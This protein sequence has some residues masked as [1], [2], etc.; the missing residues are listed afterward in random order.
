MELSDFGNVPQGLDGKDF[1]LFVQEIAQH[2]P[3]SVGL[4]LPLGNVLSA[5][6]NEMGA[7]RMIE[8]W[9]VCYHNT[10][11]W[12]KSAFVSKSGTAQQPSPGKR[13][14]DPAAS[15]FQEPAACLRTLTGYLLWAAGIPVL[16]YGSQKL[17]ILNILFVIK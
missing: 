16:R 3:T 8:K 7:E 17:L 12:V 11:H 10:A 13:G 6:F 4:L 9:S 1:Q 15:A 14:W 2:N 5:P